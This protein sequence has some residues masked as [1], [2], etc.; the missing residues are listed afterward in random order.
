[1][2]RTIA[3]RFS[4]DIFGAQEGGRDVFFAIVSTTL[5]R[6]RKKVS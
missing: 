2:V 3:K 4:A 1:M 5:P 6:L